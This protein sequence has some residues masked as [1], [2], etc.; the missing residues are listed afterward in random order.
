MLTQQPITTVIKR[1]TNT[2]WQI[3]GLT[4]P[5]TAGSVCGL[6]P[7]KQAF[8]KLPPRYRAWRPTSSRQNVAWG[9][10]ADGW[11]RLSLKAAQEGVGS[12][13]PQHGVHP[14][15]ERQT[16]MQEKSVVCP[17]GPDGTG[18]MHLLRQTPRHM[19]VSQMPATLQESAGY[20][21]GTSLQGQ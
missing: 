17:P 12:Y 9:K 21:L 19:E 14:H 7:W 20:I 8:V 6:Q 16:I 3:S 1:A 11:P 13:W 5:N 2:N 4:K 18:P 15:R 10:N